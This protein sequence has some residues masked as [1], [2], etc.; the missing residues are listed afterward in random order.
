MDQAGP[1]RGLFGRHG[2]AY[3]ILFALI[4]WLFAMAAMISGRPLD[5]LANAYDQ[6]GKAVLFT[7][8]ACLWVLTITLRSLRRGLPHPLAIV[9]RMA[10]RDRHWLL[11]TALLF[12]ITEPA[13]TSFSILK[14]SIPRFVPF[15]ADPYLRDADRFIFGTDAWRLTH[16]ALGPAATLVL[17]RAYVLYFVVLVV[18][19]VWLCTTRDLRFQ[20]R[21]LLTFISIWMFLGIFLATF[22]SSVGPVFYRAFH[23]EGSFDPLLRQLAAIDRQYGL[24]M[25]QFSDWLREHATS[26]NFG[27][28]ISAMPSL[29]VGKV[30]FVLMLAHHRWGYHWLTYLAGVFFAVMWV[31]SVHLAWH[32]AVDGLVSIVA[33]TLIWYG[34]GRLVEGLERQTKL[35]GVER[36]RLAF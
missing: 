10:W 23:H 3:G 16:A 7:A 20:I 28:G 29:H 33:V 9:R 32:Y 36:A 1:S 19:L 5:I 18:I 15:Y 31:A 17:D 24:A 6:P 12:A 13:V 26:G 4:A 11:R 27:T 2:I 8:P 25:I 22:C 30:W 35:V 34:A 14:A 21:G